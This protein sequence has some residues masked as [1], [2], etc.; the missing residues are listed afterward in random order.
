MLFPYKI[1]TLLK[2]M[3][4]ANWVLMVVTA[5]LS[6]WALFVGDGEFFAFALS[7]WSATGLL[8]HMFLHADIFH[9]LGN[10]LML[11][12][13]G[14]AVCG[15]AGNWHY[16]AL[17]LVFGVAGGCAHLFF[18]HGPI[19]GASG[20]INGVVGMATALY[21]RN[22]VSVFYF[23]WIK[24]GFF[25]APLWV[26]SLLW[27]VWDGVYVLVGTFEIAAWA[28]IGGFFAGLVMGLLW[29]KLRIVTLG[30]WDNKSL[31]ELLGL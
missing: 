8:G 27:L 31:A 26:L 2:E 23:L 20:A 29:L 10:L 6:L 5:V 12:V 17:Y 21:P 19:V 11:W 16:L 22:S 7:D 14:N 25:E 1:N 28:H 13:F 15:N 18:S 24:P 3:P 30:E 4:V 9:L